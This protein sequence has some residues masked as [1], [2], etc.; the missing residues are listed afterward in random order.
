MDIA[1][2][3]QGVR[4]DALK[5]RAA[6]HAAHPN[7]AHE[8]A[9]NFLDS[10]PLKRDSTVSAYIAIGD[11]PDAGPLMKALR[12]HG[13]AIVLPRVVGKEKPLAFH[14]YEAGAKLMPG[15][16]GLS[17]PGTDWP[18]ADP[19]VLIVPL[20]A[21]DAEG[22]RLGYGAGFYDRTLAGLR[23]RKKVLA[24]GYALSKLER[25]EVPHHEGDQKLDWIVTEKIARKF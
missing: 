10:I 12:E 14:R 16:F 2:L 4:D 20:L 1:A 6:L 9:E 24:V 13:C 25:D 7:A 11:E 23:A 15:P 5:R 18:L 3:K 19:D 17:Q 22:N 21:F 8:M